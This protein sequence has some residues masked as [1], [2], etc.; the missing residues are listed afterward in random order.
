[1]TSVLGL[2]I[3]IFRI[4]LDAAG[5]QL[6]SQQCGYFHL[7]RFTNTDGSLSLDGEIGCNFGGQSN[8]ERIPFTYNTR[9]ALATPVDRLLV[10]WTAQPGK[11]AEILMTRDPR[12]LD[13][14]NTPAR[15]VVIQG[16][17]AQAVNSSATIG[18]SAAQIIAANSARA[19]AIIQ[20]NPLNTSN[21]YIGQ[22]GLT[23][24]NGIILNPGSS[25]EW[26][27]VN[28]VF[29]IADAAGQNARIIVEN[30]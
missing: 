1:M 16:T 5:S 21:L 22:T 10:D 13:G 2:E 27:G 29:G 7:W 23:V 19:R 28:A 25:Y 9:L 8:Q 6:I 30:F 20:A 14:Q 26:R 12:G 17:A 11:T 18:T 3:S 4:P 24:G 15:Q